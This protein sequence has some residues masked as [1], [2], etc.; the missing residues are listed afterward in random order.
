MLFGNFLFLGF[1]DCKIFKTCHPGS[2]PA[3]DQPGAPRHADADIIQ[4]YVYSSD[5]KKKGLKVLTI[6]VTNSLIGVLYG[7]VSA[8]ENVLW[9]DIPLL[10]CAIG[11]NGRP[12]QCIGIP[13]KEAE[14]AM[15]SL[16]VK[17]P[18]ETATD[19]FKVLD[20]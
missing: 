10:N 14:N 20:S 19:L 16:R 11:H 5:V 3:K 8:W 2:G 7:T 9:F 17:W 18:Y 6:A 12:S 15:R 13:K 1:V 4:K